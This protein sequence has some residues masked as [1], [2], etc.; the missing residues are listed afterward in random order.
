ML[1]TLHDLNDLK[2]QSITVFL[3][4]LETLWQKLTIRLWEI[5]HSSQHSQ[6]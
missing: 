4:S 1:C 2:S 3:A 6:A 5:P